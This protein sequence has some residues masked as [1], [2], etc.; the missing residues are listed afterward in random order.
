MYRWLSLAVAMLA[1][2]AS[3]AIASASETSVHF[4]PVNSSSTDSGTCGPDWASD[5]YKRAFDA[6][7]T[8]NSDG[9]FIVT[10]TFISGRFVTIEGVSP[11]SCDNGVTGGTIAGGVKGTFNGY[12]LVVISGGAFNAAATCDVTS[13]GTTAAFVST[14]YG[15]SAIGAVTDFSF[16]YH[17]NGPGLAARDWQNASANQGGNLGDIANA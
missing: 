12:F 5:T 8:P 13:C 6:S 3:P 15:P 16:Q 11:G 17:A 4:G 14:V 7:T 9:N 2:A 1:L 10:E